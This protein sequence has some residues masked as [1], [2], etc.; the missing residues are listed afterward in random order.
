MQ[1]IKKFK[2]VDATDHGLGCTADEVIAALG[3]LRNRKAEP[4]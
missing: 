2:R 4:D 1:M 3:L